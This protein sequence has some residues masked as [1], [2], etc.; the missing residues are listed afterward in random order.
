MFTKLKSKF[1]EIVVVLASVA[2]FFIGVALIDR[3]FTSNYNT[4]VVFD[5]ITYGLMIASSIML[6]V[7]GVKKE[8]SKSDI[9][10]PVIL[11][12]SSYVINY[13]YAIISNDF[14]GADR[15]ILYLLLYVAGIVLYLL[16]LNNNKIRIF[17]L[18]IF[19]IITTI[20]ACS[21]LG[22]S[23]FGLSIL[24]QMVIF[25]I[26]IFTSDEENN[27]K[28]ERMENELNQTLSLLD[29]NNVIKIQ[30]KELI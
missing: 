4:G 22:G 24:I 19:A 7:L 23:T 27:S 1:S 5:I 26:I 15:L 11:L 16:T 28:L 20:F 12:F 8:L 17:C 18:I 3:I 30:V 2:T 14:V 21:F 10:I 13:V 29:E 6:I 9:T 25:D